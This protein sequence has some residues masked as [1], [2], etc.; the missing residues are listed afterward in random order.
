VRSVPGNRVFPTFVYFPT[1]RPEP[2]CDSAGD[3]D[4]AQRRQ[5]WQRARPPRHSPPAQSTAR[6]LFKRIW[7]QR[8]QSACQFFGWSGTC[9][10]LVPAKPAGPPATGRGYRPSPLCLPSPKNAV[11]L[12]FMSEKPGLAELTVR[13]IRISHF[14]TLQNIRVISKCLRVKPTVA[15]KKRR[16]FWVNCLSNRVNS[17]GEV[18]G[19]S[20]NK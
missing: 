11:P 7:R 12:F 3:I 8:I 17:Y 19:S 6:I 13:W 18:L 14:I 1:G 9:T 4:F 10:F 20:L 2:C 5:P 16:W 15:D